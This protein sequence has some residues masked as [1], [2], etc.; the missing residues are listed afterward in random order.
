MVRC[1]WNVSFED[2]IY[3]EPSTGQNDGFDYGEECL[4]IYQT[5]FYHGNVKK[6]NFSF[7]WHL[8]NDK[9]IK[10]QCYIVHKIH[11]FF[12]SVR[13]NWVEAQYV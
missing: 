5:K 6:N 7:S 12:I 11:S 13:V 8:Q 4:R 10:N 3:N 2:L 1:R 9:K